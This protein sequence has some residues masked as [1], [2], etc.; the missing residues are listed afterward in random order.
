MTPRS[1]RHL[2][3]A[4]VA[5]VVFVVLLSLAR[6]V[7]VPRTGYGVKSDEATCV[8]MALSVACDGDLTYERGT[9][10]GSPACITAD[11]TA[12]S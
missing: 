7:D 5:F 2:G 9:S 4:L 10:N 8:A 6:S 3:P 1:H 11:R 12:S